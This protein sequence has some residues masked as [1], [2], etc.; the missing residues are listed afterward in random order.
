[1]F[2]VS[3]P[4]RVLSCRRRQSTELQTCHDPSNMNAHDL[5]HRL[6]DEE[7]RRYLTEGYL[8][9]KSG[10]PQDVHDH[11]RDRCE[12]IFSTTGNPSNEILEMNP[13][14]RLVFADPVVK[15]ALISILGDGY[16]MHPHRHCHQNRSGTPAQANHKDSYEE[17]VNVHHHRSRWAMA[18][19]YPQDV[20]ADMGPTGVTSGS[21][22]FS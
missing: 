19:Y 8:V 15:G 2:K 1:M 22:Y 13:V 11:I 18:M 17:D 5:L 16:F 3:L 4:A 21:Q 20:T 6:S 9:L 10:L 14:L 12:E 7:M